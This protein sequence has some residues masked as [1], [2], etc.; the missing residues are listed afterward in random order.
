MKNI[1]LLIFGL[2]VVM[3][4]CDKKGNIIDEKP[5]GLSTNSVSLFADETTAT[6]YTNRTDW[7][8]VGFADHNT[9][10][11]IQETQGSQTGIDETIYTYD[12]M[13]VRK[14]GLDK[15]TIELQ[16]NGPP[17]NPG[18]AVPCGRRSISICLSAGGNKE[19]ITVDQ[20]DVPAYDRFSP[21]EILLPMNG[22]RDII[23]TST[24]R[25]WYLSSFWDS[26]NRTSKSII[27]KTELASIDET[28]H[29]YKW[30]SVYRSG[31]TDI[32]VKAESNPTGQKRSIQIFID[33]QMYNQILTVTQGK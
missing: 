10:E 7:H 12:W 18:G 25:G 19:Y 1:I 17:Y 28:T 13:S 24:Y 14:A 9:K 4:S 29:T 16:P 27:D 5:I 23:K 33:C 31:L 8:F 6:V 15:M 30:L 22:G 11:I 3:M 26:E 2:A 32:V 20:K 21:K